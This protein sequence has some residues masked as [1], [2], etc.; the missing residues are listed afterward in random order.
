MTKDMKDP[1]K[2]VKLRAHI[3]LSRYK[4]LTIVVNIIKKQECKLFII[5]DEKALL[6][7]STKVSV[8]MHVTATNA[9]N[10]DDKK[11]A[12]VT[13]FRH[14]RATTPLLLLLLISA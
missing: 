11:S 3:F 7:R 1:N 4:R 14:C 13:Y 12:I 5:W 8:F 6:G 10:F 2:L 9:T